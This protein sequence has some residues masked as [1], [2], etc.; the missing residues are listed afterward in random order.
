MI[1]KKRGKEKRAPQKIMVHTVINLDHRIRVTD[2]KLEPDV[3]R[4]GRRR[5]IVRI[6]LERAGP[7]IARV[8][9]GH[10][11]LVDLQADKSLGLITL[12]EIGPVRQLVGL[13]HDH[14][15][16]LVHARGMRVGVRGDGARLV[17]FKGEF[18]GVP[19]RTD[20][21]FGIGHGGCDPGG[22]A[23]FEAAVLDDVVGWTGGASGAGGR[24]GR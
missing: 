3:R 16:I 8:G 24:G 14:D 15:Q 23:T 13:S 12:V 20:G 2:E 1:Q 18:G 6:A 10:R 4:I 17:E 21:V 19:G 9:R 22:K 11:L 5:E 7:E